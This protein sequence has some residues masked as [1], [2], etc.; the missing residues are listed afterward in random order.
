[1]RYELTDDEWIAI[2]PMLPN[3]PR[4][5]PRVSDRRVLNGIFWVLRASAHDETCRVQGRGLSYPV[6]RAQP[7]N[8]FIRALILLFA[9]CGY[10]E[11]TRVAEVGLS[12]QA[13]DDTF[14]PGNVEQNFSLSASQYR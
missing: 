6:I 14:T 1:M 5:A 11:C 4:G 12:A 10:S 13:S 8:D 3:K 2:K 7:V 9:H